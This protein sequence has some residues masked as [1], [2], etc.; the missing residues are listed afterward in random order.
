[1]K[2]ETAI[3][4]PL[5]M[6]MKKEIMGQSGINISKYREDFKFGNH[7]HTTANVSIL[8]MLSNTLKSLHSHSSFLQHKSSDKDLKSRIQNLTGTVR[9]L[10]ES[11]DEE[12]QALKSSLGW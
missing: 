11:K 6:V 3:N 10:E 1:M 2:K 8:S 7:L 12:K 4:Y 9:L 5:Q